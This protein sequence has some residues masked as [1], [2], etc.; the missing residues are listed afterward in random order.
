[1]KLVIYPYIQI[2]RVISFKLILKN[3]S[4]EL[5]SQLRHANSKM[6]KLL[7]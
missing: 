2:L 5:L 6:V 4:H 3:R 1:M 7:T